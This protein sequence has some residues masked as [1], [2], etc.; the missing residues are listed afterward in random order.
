[1]ERY[2]RITIEEELKME[3]INSPGDENFDYVKMSELIGALK[4]AWQKWVGYRI[5]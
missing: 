5:V 3:D 4:L 1:M 2:G